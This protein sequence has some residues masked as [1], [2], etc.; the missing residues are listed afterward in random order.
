MNW[1]NMPGLSSGDVPGSPA[2]FL[3][4]RHYSLLSGIEGTGQEYL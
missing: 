2:L 1:L 4:A 3:I